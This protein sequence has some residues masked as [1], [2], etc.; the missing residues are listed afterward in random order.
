MFASEEEALAA[1]EELYGRYLD[2]DQ[3]KS[4]QAGWNDVV[5]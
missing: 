3:C 4:A 1:A 2:A 5:A